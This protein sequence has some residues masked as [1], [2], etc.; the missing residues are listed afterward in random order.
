M[1]RYARKKCESGIYHIIVRGINRQEKRD[2]ILRQL[3]E[4]EGVSH[5]QIAMG[6]RNK[7]QYCS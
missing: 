5:R 6:N 7:S 4:I 3:K 1:P 2:E